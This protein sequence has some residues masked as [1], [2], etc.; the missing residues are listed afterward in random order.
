MADENEDPDVETRRELY[1]T[2]RAKRESVDQLLQAKLAELK[3]LCLKEAEI[4]GHLPPETPLKPNEPRPT[5]RRRVRTEFTLDDKLLTEGQTEEEQRLSK[6]E[7]DVVTQR[8]IVEA[9]KKLMNESINQKKK[10]Y[11][12]RKSNYETARKKLKD[13]EARL[14]AARVQIQ[15]EYKVKM[16]S[17]KRLIEQHLSLNGVHHHPVTTNGYH[18]HNLINIQNIPAPPSEDQ[19]LVKKSA[20]S[21]KRKGQKAAKVAFNSVPSSPVITRELRCTPLSPVDV[22]DDQVNPPLINRI[23][24][25]TLHVPPVNPPTPPSILKNGCK[26]SQQQQQ[27]S[28]PTC[29]LHSGKRSVAS[30]DVIDEIG[31]NV[32]AIQAHPQH[33]QLTRS[34]SSDNVRRK[35]YISAVNSP[36]TQ[37]II[38]G[39]HYYNQPVLQQQKYL[40]KN[41]PPP[42]PN[43]SMMAKRPLPPTPASFGKGR[44]IPVGHFEDENQYLQ[45]SSSSCEWIMV[46]HPFQ[47]APE[48]IQ[49]TPTQTRRNFSLQQQPQT[50]E[51]STPVDIS[52]K[53]VR[54][55]VIRTP[56]ITVSTTS[57]SEAPIAQ[58]VSINPSTCIHVPVS[59][60]PSIASSV[61]PVPSSSSPCPSP[62]STPCKGMRNRAYS[63]PPAED[64]PPLPD[65]LNCPSPTPSSASTLAARMAQQMIPQEEHQIM[66]PPTGL[67]P[68]KP[69]KGVGSGRAN[70]PPPLNL[71]EQPMMQ[72]SVT[73]LSEVTPIN[74]PLPPE[75]PGYAPETPGLESE[76]FSDSLIVN[77]S[78]TFVS[79]SRPCVETPRPDPI[80][81][82]PQLNVPEA[83]VD[84]VAVGTYTPYWE[85]T[86]PFEMSDFLKYSS[87]HRKQQQLVKQE[88][89]SSSTSEETF[90]QSSHQSVHHHRQQSLHAESTKLSSTTTSQT[91]DS[92]GIT[93]PTTFNNLMNGSF[94]PGTVLSQDFT[95]EML[96]WYEETVKNGTVV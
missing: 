90:S 96:D 39:A 9:F 16:A 42:I 17:R 65:S 46:E 10:I 71:T 14:E 74:L 76:V 1:E 77:P 2:L 58:T 66:G 56:A 48:Q 26:R 20:S 59:S 69:K 33:Q 78:S 31:S 22:D 84:V 85:E 7:L 4:T 87:K 11:K 62:Q 64:Y 86:K 3:A 52:L 63:G 47:S 83:V 91:T 27:H 93:S 6:L 49:T 51:K 24:S 95:D 15:E 57:S 53:A 13:L 82:T 25:T 79:S 81:I 88:T 61:T 32:I 18:S 43:G 44:N 23:S 70:I 92:H 89:S 35:S 12:Q 80:P 34:N 94:M 55:S 29:D 5:I 45:S 28:V 75:T 72:R 8:N 30:E 38:R 36:P 40:P 19:F 54:S 21:R 37:P 68:R 67:P 73:P 41:P 60:A 50:P